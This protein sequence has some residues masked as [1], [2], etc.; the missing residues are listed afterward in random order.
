MEGRKNALIVI[1]GAA[2]IRN[3]AAA[4]AAVLKSFTVTVLTAGEFSGTQLLAADIC[5]FGSETP[6]PPSFAY[7]GTVLGH[8][9][10]AGRPCGVFSTSVDGAEYLRNLV[11]DS[12]ITLYPVVLMEGKDNVK[13]WTESV[14]AQLKKR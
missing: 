13:K 12:E 1:D 2:P 8:I 10:L 7:L 9:N 6:N 11:H 14:T 3:M 5:F 4:I